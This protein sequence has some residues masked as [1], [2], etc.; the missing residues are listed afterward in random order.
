MCYNSGRDITGLYRRK[1]RLNEGFMEK[2]GKRG[3]ANLEPIAPKIVLRLI[4]PSL[5]FQ[6][7]FLIERYS[8]GKILSKEPGLHPFKILPVGF[9]G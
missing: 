1:P 9:T 4:N 7:L 8:W 2:N 5:S 6:S 3:W